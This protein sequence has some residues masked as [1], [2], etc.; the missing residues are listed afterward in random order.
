LQRIFE[1]FVQADSGDARAH[2]GTGLGLSIAG[3]LVER[4]GGRITVDSVPDRG[5]TFSFCIPLPQHCRACARALQVRAV[6][7]QQASAAAAP[8]AT[9]A[10]MRVLLTEDNDVN[11]L[12]ITAMLDGVGVDVDRVGDGEAAIECWRSRRHDL[13]LM[14]IQMPGMDGHAATREIRRIEA[15]EGWPATPV[16]ALTAYAF[17][18]DARRSLEAAARGS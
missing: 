15:A 7:R 17:A 10:P 9:S 8:V 1:P 12:L 16:Y 2:G 5:S 3:N 4:M 6:R 13:V 14:D 11:A 18:D